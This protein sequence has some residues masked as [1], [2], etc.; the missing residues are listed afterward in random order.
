VPSPPS[1]TAPAGA[2]LVLCLGLCA[3]SS[4]GGLPPFWEHESGLPGNL[5]EDRAVFGLIS[6]TRGPDGALLSAIRPF[7]AKVEDGKGALKAHYVPPIGMHVEDESRVKTTVWPLF[8]D[9]SFG[10]ETER[11]EK[12]SDDDTWIFPLVGWGSAPKGHGDWFALF[13]FYGKLRG[14]FLADEVDFVLFPIYVHTEAGDWRSTHVIWPLIAWGESP[15]RDHFRV[16]PFWSQTDSPTQSNRT[17]IWPIG[18]WGWETHGD[19]VFD[20]WQAWPLVGRR[21]SRDGLYESTSVLWPFF[22]FAHDDKNGDDYV[23]APW[24]FYVNSVKPGVSEQKWFWPFYGRFDS[25]TDH[26]RFYAWPIVW[27]ADFVEGR[28]EFHHTYVVPLWMQRSSGPVNGAVDEKECRS[29]PLFS[30][31]RHADGVER[32]RFPEIIPFFGWEAGETCYADILTLYHSS[33]DDEGR[34]A[35]DGP[36]GAVRYRR[37]E[38]GKKTL[39]LLWWIDIPLGGGG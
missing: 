23:G 21:T 6:K 39:T 30:W 38:K 10:D 19:R 2:I 22:E 11:R 18:G 31:S 5:S 28:R 13:P 20:Y 25:P 37:N 35:W 16:M 15:T 29:W 36:L 27:D 32:F 33:S 24:P 26:S 17:L 12:T 9:A 7:T 3:C 4:K 14:S 1:S 34:L 8:S